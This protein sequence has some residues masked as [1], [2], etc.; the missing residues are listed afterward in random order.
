VAGAALR[1]IGA[2]L[3]SAA[4]VAGQAPSP[5]ALPRELR[6]HVQNGRF[7]I[8]SSLNGLPGG[9]RAELQTL[10][11]GLRMDIVDPGAAFQGTSETADSRLAQRRL[12]AAGCSY[13]D[14]LVYYE[15]AGSSRTWRVVLLHWTAKGTTLEWGGIAPGGL[16]T[17]HDVRTAVL[18]G[19]IKSSAGPW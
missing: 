2:S 9:V 7:D 8:V 17:I 16:D 1:L 11:G 19:A 12:V 10:F 3:W 13:E 14:C 6:A 18:S 15:R 5:T 4:A